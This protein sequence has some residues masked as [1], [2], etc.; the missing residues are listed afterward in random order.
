MK[1]KTTSTLFTATLTMFFTVSLTA[2]P[3]KAEEKP[4]TNNIGSSE[5]LLSTNANSL[6]S[7]KS[8]SLTQDSTTR[9]R[10]GLSQ[11]E[12]DEVTNNINLQMQKTRDPNWKREKVWFE[13]KWDSFSTD[14]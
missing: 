7:G 13:E 4:V 5:Q 2:N 11:G 12:L 6:S 1:I 9:G 3:A 14:F 8:M 10:R